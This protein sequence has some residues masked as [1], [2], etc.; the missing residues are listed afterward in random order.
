MVIVTRPTSSDLGRSWYKGAQLKPGPSEGQRPPPPP[1]QPRT[2]A[3][4]STPAARGG[5]WEQ[6]YPHAFAA[7]SSRGTRQ[8]QGALGGERKEQLVWG[9]DHAGHGLSAGQRRTCQAGIMAKTLLLRG[10]QH[11]D[12][13]PRRPQGRAR[14]AG[15]RISLQ[16]PASGSTFKQDPRV[17][18]MLLTVER[19][20]PALTL[21][22]SPHGRATRG[23]G[24]TCEQSVGRSRVRDLDPPAPG[25]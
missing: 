3:L 5:L 21:G 9:E 16:T 25:G 12:L 11:T 2:W 8:A 1:P 10:W 4:I 14:N 7:V 24:H 6:T 19:D 23:P 15:S 20:A 18:C 22:N 13:Q 17:V